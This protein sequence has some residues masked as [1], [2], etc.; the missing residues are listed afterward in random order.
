MAA[1]GACI[2]KDFHYPEK[3][4]PVFKDEVDELPEDS[5]LAMSQSEIQIR[6]QVQKAKDALELM[7]GGRKTIIGEKRI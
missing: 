7:G 4:T 6:N 3:P 5:K 2:S 1:I